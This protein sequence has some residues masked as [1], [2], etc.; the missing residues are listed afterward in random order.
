MGTLKAIKS[1][2][3]NPEDCLVE[4]VDVFLKQ[5]EQTWEDVALA[6][7]KPAGGADLHLARKIA[8]EHGF[9]PERITGPERSAKKYIGAL[10]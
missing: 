5:G 8:R 2:N 10:A 6:V 9:S 3:S 4:V 7:A 1:S